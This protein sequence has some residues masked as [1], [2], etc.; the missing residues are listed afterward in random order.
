[1]DTLLQCVYI[2]DFLFFYPYFIVYI[3]YTMR[4]T[5]IK[6]DKRTRLQKNFQQTVLKLYRKKTLDEITINEV[7]EKVGVPRSSFYYHYNTIRDVLEEIEKDF[8]KELSKNL[9]DLEVKEAGEK[10]RYLKTLE[11]SLPVIKGYEQF[12]KTVVVERQDLSFMTRWAK[13]I[14]EQTRI[15]Q[16]DPLKE[17]VLAFTTIFSIADMLNSSIP[18]AKI[19]GE[20]IYEA[21]I[22]LY[23]L[24][25]Q[26]LEL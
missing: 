6:K 20:T 21:S 2:I 23:E 17:R 22:H 18:L 12:I 7:C 24:K 26:L 5:A 9:K 3:V 14:A 10:E 16:Q 19:K 15:A 13:L 4:K 1:M 11:S 25:K 8:I